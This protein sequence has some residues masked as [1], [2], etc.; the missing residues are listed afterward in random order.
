MRSRSLSGT[1]TPPREPCM[2][3]AAAN[4]PRGTA[5]RRPSM[6]SAISSLYA[7]KFSLASASYQTCASRYF[8]LGSSSALAHARTRFSAASPSHARSRSARGRSP[9]AVTA[10]SIVLSVVG[11]GGAELLEQRP[12]RRRQELVL[13]LVAHLHQRDVGEAGLP[14]R[15]DGL[16]HGVQV[17]AA[18]DLLGHV[19]R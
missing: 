12:G 6:T 10:M 9:N 17:R 11:G 7:V 5:F 3:A 1:S 4:T 18:R 13:P 16:D 2:T 8:S 14:V 15:G 19:G